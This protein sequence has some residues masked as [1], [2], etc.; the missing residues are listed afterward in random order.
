[1]RPI[2]ALLPCILLA[3]AAAGCSTAGQD[4]L[5][6]VYGPD[7]TLVDGA[8][9][10]NGAHLE[11]RAG[12]GAWAPT[13]TVS[14]EGGKVE[15]PAMAAPAPQGGGGDRQL[16]SAVE[17]ALEVR[18]VERARLGGFVAHWFVYGAQEQAGDLGRAQAVLPAD[19]PFAAKVQVPG[20]FQVTA[21]LTAS[22]ADT[23]VQ[24][25]Y[26]G[27]IQGILSA[28]WTVTGQV[29]P[30]S[31][32]Q[33]PLLPPTSPPTAR[34]Q[35][36]DTFQV[37][38]STGATVTASTK[39]NGMFTPDKGTD[40]DLGLYT[41]DGKGIVCSSGGGAAVPVAGGGVPAPDPSQ[42]TESLTAPTDAAGTWSIEVGAQAN[43]CPPSVGGGGQSYFY[44]NAGPVPYTLDIKVE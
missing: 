5:K 6:A 41:P 17:A 7:F 8:P 24:A 21:Y 30:V 12:E 4:A 35:M 33:A 32:P 25:R 18:I 34:D 10:V 43:G 19:Q 3:V 28:H 44:T 29:Q 15:T 23:A 39:F 26:A 27:A 31:P 1:M 11:A 36:V 20:P 14:M 22:V 42:S 2:P 37:Q 13:V 38:V 40:V 16:L 9:T